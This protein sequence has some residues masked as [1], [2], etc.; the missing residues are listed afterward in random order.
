MKA[1]RV[2]FGRQEEIVFGRPAA[3]AAAEIAGRYGAARVFVMASGTL[4]R[5][6]KV[7]SDIVAALG[8]RFAVLFDSMPA[9]TPRGACLAA[10]SMAREAGADLILTVG[11]GSVTDGA[12]AVS[13]LLANDISD[14]VGM[15]ALRAPNPVKPPVVRQ[16]SVPTTLSAGE[17]SALCG[18]TDE[19]T[20]AKELFT[21]P[22][23]IPCAVILDPAATV[24]T[25]E[26]L[27]LS[28]GV[29]AVDHCA[30]GVASLEGHHYGDAQ[31]MKGLALLA[32]GLARVKADAGDLEARLDCLTGAW[33]SMGP[34]AS[35]VP[36]G[37]SHGI[38]YV[39]GARH[40][41]PHG[42]TSCVMLPAA[43]EWNMSANRDR[44]ALVAEAMGRRDGDAATALAAL[45][46]G[47]GMPRTLA[48]VGV[49]EADWPGIAEGAMKTPWVPRNPRRIEGPAAVMEILRLAA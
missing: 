33:L 26:W 21:H 15:D 25:P 4:N 23:V 1:G 48:A 47:I 39:L 16:V 38:G 35:G 49:T 10:A 31:G 29:R 24:P 2:A 43:M 12:K 3:E 17:F 7:V 11:G 18:V 45:I 37:A 44:Q 19:R 28:T 27:F 32:S 30:E 9:H 40:G 8:P 36:M 22:L 41:V 34:L 6:T 46:E 14:A 13:L 20:K 5:E 42:H